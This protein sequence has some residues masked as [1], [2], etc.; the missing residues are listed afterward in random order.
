MITRFPCSSESPHNAGLRPTREVLALVTARDEDGN[1][2][3]K[4]DFVPS[5]EF[6]SK[7]R[8]CIGVALWEER[9]GL[10]VHCLLRRCIMISV[11]VLDQVAFLGKPTVVGAVNPH[12]PLAGKLVHLVL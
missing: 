6:R 7:F 3:P 12:G 2:A 5:L 11:M 8:D 10:E 4:L 9:Q 1:C